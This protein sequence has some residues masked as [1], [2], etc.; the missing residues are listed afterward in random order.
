M[1]QQERHCYAYIDG[2]NLHMGIREMR[3]DLD[4]EKFRKLLR[5]KYRVSKAHIFI[6]YVESNKSLYTH[7]R[8]CGFELVF[9]EAVLQR[10]ETK[11]NVDAELVLQAVKDFY[12]EQPKQAVLVSGDGDF[13]C[14][15]DFL[16]DKGIF[17]T[18]VAP[19]R[20]YCS[21]LLRK[22]NL[23]LTYMDDIIAK[24]EKT[25]GRH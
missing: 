5:W 1:N 21:Y 11:A 24:C 14:L 9:K 23:S 12:E 7:L 16:N 18:I 10:G 6:G 4:Y 15:V 2:A 17:R 13:A 20:K 22:K 25:P 19:N 3:K 8:D